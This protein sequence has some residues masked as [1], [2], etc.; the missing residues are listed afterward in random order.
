MV[1]QID[2][3]GQRVYQR[4]GSHPIDQTRRQ[5]G[6]KPSNPRCLGNEESN[7]DIDRQVIKRKLSENHEAGRTR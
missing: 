4:R 2:S 3:A 7:P 1:R 5:L 6:C